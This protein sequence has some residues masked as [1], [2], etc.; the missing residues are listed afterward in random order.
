MISIQTG[1]KA[2]GPA[3]W[4]DLLSIFMLYSINIHRFVAL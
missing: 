3:K 1:Y 4:P 2:K